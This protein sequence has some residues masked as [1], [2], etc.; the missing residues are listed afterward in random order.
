MGPPKTPP[1]IMEPKKIL[2]A[3]GLALSLVNLLTARTNTGNTID[4]ENGN[5]VSIIKYNWALLSMNIMKNFVIPYNV[6]PINAEN[7]T[8]IL[9]I[10]NPV[11]VR[12]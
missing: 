7:F 11:T 6:K 3:K 8:P 5:M 1:R 12:P 4:T 2:K 10:M 9:S